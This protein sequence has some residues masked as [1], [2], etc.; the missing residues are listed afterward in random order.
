MN[1]RLRRG[2]DSG[3]ALLLALIIVT[4]VAVVTSVVLT[5][6]DT[7]LRVTVNAVRPQA[8]TAANADGA[9]Q[10]AVNT[11][12]NSTYVSGPNCFGANKPTLSLPNFPAAGSSA[13]VTCSADPGSG[14]PVPVNDQNKPAEA[15]LTLGA[16]ANEDGINIKV[17]SQGTLLVH[18]GIFSNS[19]VNVTLGSLG[20]DTAN[21]W[22]LARKA[23]TGSFVG[24][25]GTGSFPNMIC[26]YNVANDPRSVDPNYPAPATSGLNYTVQ[27]VPTC[28]KGNSTNKEV[29]FQPGVYTNA[30]ALSTFM[31]NSGCKGAIFVFQPGIYF[32]NFGTSGGSADQW[33]INT[34]TLIGGVPSAAAAASIAAGNTPAVPGS[35]VNPLKT[36]GSPGNPQQG[37]QFVFGGDSQMY[38]RAA[39]VELC[40]TY[41]ATSPPVV[42]Y[43]LKAAVGPVAGQTIPAETGCII[44]TP[45]PSSGCALIKSDNSPNSKIFL[46]G[47]TYGPLAP[48][49]IGLNNNTAQVFEDGLVAR[50]LFLNPTGSGVPSG[51]V[52]DLP[53][54]SPGYTD[55]DSVVGLA[56]YVCLNASTCDSTT[57]KLS[58]QARLDI[59]DKTI[60]SPLAGVRKMTI[61]NW[62]FQR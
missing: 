48:L 37:V 7:N 41:S 16:L 26:N 2:D 9:A 11:L 1:R 36:V 8:A 23:C 5:F 39:S 45:Y 15:V 10:I 46:Q 62:A 59:I 13:Y 53:D 61:L 33:T 20:T 54:N 27:S 42:V 44:A 32:F 60:G 58:L 3:A 29:D 25:G 21:T 28:P 30:A 57:G 38:V 18:G 19:N 47:T 17:A 34:G 52:I 43:G 4:V 24:P 12:R 49:D 22:L 14:V 31:S 55:G 56:V 51:P 6:A 40:G 35:C 50:T